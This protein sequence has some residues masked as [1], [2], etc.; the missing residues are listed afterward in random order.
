MSNY[1]CVTSIGIVHFVYDYALLLPFV[2]N[3]SLSSR[4]I[5]N[6]KEL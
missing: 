3:H 5:L 2:T 6:D 1:H 4:N